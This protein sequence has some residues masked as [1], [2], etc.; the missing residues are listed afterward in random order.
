MKYANLAWLLRHRRLPHYKVAA[1]VGMS[2]RAFSHAFT[3]RGDFT[4]DQKYA[5]AKL[6]DVSSVWLFTEMKPPRPRWKPKVR[7]LVVS[8]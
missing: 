5:L 7:D 6:L 8:A 3:G 2:Q 1:S 4:W